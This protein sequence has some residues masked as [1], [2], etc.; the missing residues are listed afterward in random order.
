MRRIAGV[1]GL[2]ALAG[3]SNEGLNPIVQAG[4]EQV[5]ARVRGGEAAAPA[6]GLTRADIEAT[7]TAT[8]RGRLL[9]DERG[10]LLY[11]VVENNGVVTYAS[12]LR[13][14]IGLRGN[15]LVA[16]RGLGHDLLAATSSPDDPVVR[17]TPPG[18]WPAGV[19][20]SY[21]FP[22]NAPQGRV[23]RYDCRFEFGAARTISIL[24]VQHRG[25]EVAE[26]CSG[27]AGEFENLY[28]ADLAT[29]FV[30]RSIQWSGPEQ[31]PIDI[32]VIVPR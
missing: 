17:P 14:T 30:W 25:V 12:Q 32:E 8:I 5:G 22:A 29:G 1:L 7:G 23:E 6:E 3:C 9:D 24:T 26:Y 20:R 4:V 10:T 16:T 21:T 2:L 31:G 19:T 13:Q 11:G 27:E 15:L 28:F 18:G